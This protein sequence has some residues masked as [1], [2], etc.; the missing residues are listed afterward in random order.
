LSA[1]IR[2]AAPIRICDLGGWTDTWF[3]RHGCVFNLAVHPAVEVELRVSSADPAGTSGRP[4]VVVHA[5]N[6]GRRYVRDLDRPTWTKHPLIE[7]AL[8]SLPRRGDLAYRVNVFSAAPPGASVGSSAATAVA[9]LAAIQHLQQSQPGEE[10]AKVTPGPG[11]GA[12][13]GVGAGEPVTL[14]YAAHRLETDRLSQQAGVQDQLCAAHGGA[15]FI[16]IDQYPRARVTRLPLPDALRWELDARL[17]LVYLGRAHDSSA[18]HERVI[19]DLEDRGPEA[20]PLQALRR[21]ATAAR[22]AFVAGDLDGFGKA[23]QANT[24]AQ[25]ELHAGLIGADAQRVID[26]ARAHG[27]AGWKVNGAGGD[28]G[29][30]TILGGPSLAAQRTMLHEIEAENAAFRV[31]PIRLSV[32]GVRVWQAI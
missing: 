29:S 26:I 20:P 30:L 17:A 27:A 11:A 18:M 8:E 19:R 6:F 24:A 5:E 13:A 3:A 7:A 10:T 32:E 14:A 4:L 9:L 1:F 22:D 28:G 16:E 23:M 21:A 25:A 12:G 31:I 15:C 2:S